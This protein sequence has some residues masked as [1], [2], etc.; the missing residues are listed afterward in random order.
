MAS[1]R[2][3]AKYTLDNAMERPTQVDTGVDLPGPAIWE[4]LRIHAMGCDC[5]CG[6]QRRACL[7]GRDE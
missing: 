6:Y 7:S 3:A 5:E 2:G 4:C 1:R